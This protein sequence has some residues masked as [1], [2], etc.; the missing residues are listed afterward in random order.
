MTAT[1]AVPSPKV[2]EPPRVAV[3]LLNLRAEDLTAACVRSLNAGDYP[4]LSIV[5]VDNASADGSGERLHEA[6][7]G[8]VYLPM[9]Q[10]LG[11]TG[12]NNRGIENALAAGCDY[13]LIL[14]N[15]TVVDRAC[16]SKLIEAAQ[17]DPDA[18][19]IGGKILF[20]DAPDRIWFG[21]GDL[22]HFRAL[23]L[24][25]LEGKRD[26]DPEERG[27]REVS[28]LTGCCM[29]MPA[30]VICEVG[31]FEEDFFIYAEDTELSLR[32][33]KAG[34]QLLY[35][36]AARLYHR[37][38]IVEPPILPHKIVLRDRNRRRLVR[39]RYSL[40]G[41]VRFAL[42]FY[43]T[44]IARAAQYLLNGDRERAGAIWR[45]MTER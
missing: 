4:A 7:P 31:M 10:N 20:Y 38:P 13:V 29:L 22:S 18:G 12:G 21:G 45:G 26:P 14:N 34:Y 32:I 28:F 44:R 16:I 35:Q 30:R 39:R 24:H 43:P 2:G 37:V 17:A 8:V 15:D 5:L 36:P 40:A 25:Q 9:K 33:A 11:F 27:V 1:T 19:A 3:V 41:C 6:F 42:F 23:G